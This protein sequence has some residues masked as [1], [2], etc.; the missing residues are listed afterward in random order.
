MRRIMLYVAGLL[1]CAAVLLPPLGATASVD[2]ADFT[3]PKANPYF[4]LTPGKVFVYRGTEGGDHLVEH[5]RV[6]HRTETIEGVETTVVKDTLFANARLAEATTDWYANDNNGA[7]WYFGERTATY[8]RHGHVA[9]REGSWRSGIDDG[10]A[11]IIMAANPVPT[12]AYRQEFLTGHAEDQA[13]IV[14]NHERV[15][16]PYGHVRNVVRSFE[17]TRLEPRVVS[18]KLY[19]PGLGIVRERDV[20]GGNESLELIKVRTH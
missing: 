14:A 13:W 11:G 5:L 8:D 16:V 19:A 9:S 20:A 4:P 1:V 2:P 12:D 10:E 3:K 18:V 6:T 15:T 7:T 17:W